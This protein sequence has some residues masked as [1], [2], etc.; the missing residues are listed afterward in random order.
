MRS[1][2]GSRG[3]AGADR[4]DAHRTLEAAMSRARV[5][6][7]V[8]ATLGLGAALVA[9]P[10]PINVAAFV[11]WAILVAKWTRARARASGPWAGGAELVAKSMIMCLLVLAAVA[12]PG[13]Y[14]DQV[15]AQHITLPKQAMTIAELQEPESHGLQ[16]PFHS[17]WISAPDALAGRVVQFPARDL[18]IGEFAAAIEEQTPLRYRFGH[19]GNGST[20]LWGGDC[21]FGMSFRVRDP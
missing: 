4:L 9:T 12:A 5:A 14:V 21:S 8:V 10:I 15:K 18:T 2:S 13:K 19:C 11:I 7:H 20:I 1:E 17:Y 3:Y 6:I 16:R